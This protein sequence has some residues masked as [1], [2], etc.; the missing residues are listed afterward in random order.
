VNRV[1]QC[2]IQSGYSYT[3]KFKAEP[4]G[5]HWW[6]SHT[7]S[8]YADGIRGP[9]IVHAINDPYAGQYVAEE[10][11]FITDYMPIAGRNIVPQ[12]VK[13]VLPFP[14]V[15]PFPDWWSFSDSPWY[16]ATVNGKFDDAM[17]C[18]IE[19]H[20]SRGMFSIFSVGDPETQHP[21]L[22][23]SVGAPPCDAKY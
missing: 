9:L 8:Q 13:N 4:H 2:P 23:A 5:T 1:T 3:Y 10:V 22:P 14:N 7:G 15:G 18:H 20:A 16:G 19:W 12:I 6:H 21:K 17:H 11:L